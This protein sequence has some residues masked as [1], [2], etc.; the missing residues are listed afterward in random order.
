MQKLASHVADVKQV[1]CNSL[2]LRMHVAEN[3]FG[4]LIR[5]MMLSCF[6]F[7]ET[8]QIPLGGLLCVHVGHPPPVV[9]TL[10]LE[11][12]SGD[13]GQKIHLPSCVPSLFKCWRRNNAVLVR[14]YGDLDA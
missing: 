12:L 10:S 4:S 13:Q 14:W 5:N 8:T 1:G 2:F 11:Y 3:S 9:S 6:F 7:N